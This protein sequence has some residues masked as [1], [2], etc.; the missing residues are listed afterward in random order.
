MSERR[1]TCYEC[2]RV[3]E[4]NKLMML[5]VTSNATHGLRKGALHRLGIIVIM[6]DL[7]ALE[8]LSQVTPQVKGSKECPS[9]DK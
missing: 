2:H 7:I 6:A 5:S 1:N 3:L 9:V 8:K 4:I